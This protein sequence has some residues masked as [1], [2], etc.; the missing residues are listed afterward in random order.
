MIRWKM[1]QM[2]ATIGAAMLLVSAALGW[3][4]VDVIVK[5]R[6]AKAE[7]AAAEKAERIEYADGTQLKIT[8]P[9]ATLRVGGSTLFAEVA[10]TDARRARGLSG[11][12]SLAADAGMLFVF[13]NLRRP[14]FWMRRTLIP[15]ELAY[16]DA[17]GKIL[18]TLFLTPHDETPRCASHP[19]LYGLEL[20]PGW[21]E[22]SG[23]GIGDVIPNLP[24]GE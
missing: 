13:P 7:D 22:K 2:R 19:S 17:D 10:S 1:N 24:Q 20:N 15:L 14:C 18:Q 16:L 11:R 3:I 8:F 12:D 5:A 6:A 23:A 4:A 9:L 21:L